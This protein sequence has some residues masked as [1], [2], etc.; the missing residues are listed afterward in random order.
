MR[1]RDDKVA[2]LYYLGARGQVSKGSSADRG[3]E[4]LEC[5]IATR[6]ASRF[7]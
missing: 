7:I 4:A 3:Y 6:A 1:I 2:R 5:A